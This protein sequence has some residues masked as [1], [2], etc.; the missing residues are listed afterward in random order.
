MIQNG[1][2]FSINISPEKGTLKGKVEAVKII[3]NF[4]IEG[5]A[6]S[7]PGIRQISLLAIESIL[8]QH[9]CN[10]HFKSGDTLK[11]GDFAENI[12]TEGVDLT[13]VKLGDKIIINDSVEMVITKIGKECHHGCEVFKKTGDCIMPREGIFTS[14]IKGGNIRIGD[15]LKVI[16]I[17]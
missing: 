1:K 10:D 8:K 4:G 12:T 14:V 17:D 7:G 9:E 15:P 6:H 5:D 13:K 11:P 16:S 2:I 3:E